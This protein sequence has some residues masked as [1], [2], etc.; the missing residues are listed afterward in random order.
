M[1]ESIKTSIGGGQKD[2]SNYQ[3]TG[4]HPGGAKAQWTSYVWP[5]N[6]NASW[7]SKRHLLNGVMVFTELII[8]AA[9]INPADD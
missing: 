7:F 1:F 3:R 4:I 6:Q 5:Q 9:G 8:R 2:D